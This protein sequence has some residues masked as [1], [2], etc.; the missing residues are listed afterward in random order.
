MAITRD[1]IVALAKAYLD[2]VMV[3]QEPPSE[4][5]K[6]FLH[7]DPILFLL[8]GEDMTLQQNYELHQKLTDE[9]HWFGRMGRHAS[10]RQAGAGAC[11]RRV[12]LAGAPPG[13][14]RNRADQGLLLSGLDRA[15]HAVRRAEGRR[16][17]Q[18]R[19]LVPAGLG[20]RRYLTATDRRL[21][22]G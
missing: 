14:A 12:L 2:C 7:Q 21:D 5:Q 6:F 19:P 10:L 1:D 20:D 22:P 11:R 17:C 4:Q 9:K 8:R 13:P 3:R 18:H 16:L 15:A